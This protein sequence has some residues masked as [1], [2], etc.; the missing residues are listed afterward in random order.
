MYVE[1]EKRSRVRAWGKRKT[2]QTKAKIRARRELGVGRV[3]RPWTWIW[4]SLT[5]SCGNGNV[6]G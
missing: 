2:K 4:T 5:T 6:R 1:E 3:Y